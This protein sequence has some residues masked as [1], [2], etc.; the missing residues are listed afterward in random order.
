MSSKPE[1]DLPR[2]G[3]AAGTSAG[4]GALRRSRKAK[5]LATLGPSSEERKTIRSLCQAGVDVFRLN[6]SHGEQADHERAVKFIRSIEEEVGR[7]IG[8]LADLQGP[9][10]RVGTF[11]RDSEELEDGAAFDDSWWNGPSQLSLKSS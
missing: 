8:I 6:F 5:I 9:K 1:P 7:P 3:A 11:A 10:L 4:A 2:P